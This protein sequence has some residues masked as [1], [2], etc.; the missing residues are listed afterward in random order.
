[1]GCP[2]SSERTIFRRILGRRA[3]RRLSESPASFWVDRLDDCVRRRSPETVDL[4]RAREQLRL[5]AAI[6]FELGPNAREGEQSVVVIEGDPHE[7]DQRLRRSVVRHKTDTVRPPSPG[8][9]SYPKERRG[10]IHCY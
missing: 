9:T 4:V 8:F 7:V 3:I 2:T 10:S 1:M 5:G 6:A